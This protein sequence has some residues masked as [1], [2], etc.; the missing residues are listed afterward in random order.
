MKKKTPESIIQQIPWMP[1]AP[2]SS[3]GL[4]DNAWLTGA[5]GTAGMS[6][7]SL[8]ARYDD[9]SGMVR[10]VYITTFQKK[11]ITDRSRQ[12]SF[13]NE[14]NSACNKLMQDY[15]IGTGFEYKV[16]PTKDGVNQKLIEQVQELVDLYCEHNEM[17]K[18]EN[19][20]VWRLLVEGE[21]IVRNFAGR[22]GLLT[23]RVVEPE[24][25][26]P[27]A[28]SNNPDSSYGIEC[29]H[30]DIH[31]PVGYWIVEK[32]YEGLIPVL[33]PA[34]EINFIKMNTPSNSKRGLPMSFQVDSNFRNCESVLQSM[35][36]LANA[37][38]KVA[39]VRKIAEAP[40][41]A[42]A[43]LVA[44]TTD[45]VLNDPITNQ[46]LNIERL[47]YG[48]V[49]TSSENITYEFPNINLG[50]TDMIE[51][52]QQNLRAICSHYGLSE[53]QISSNPN[54]SNYASSV[55]AESPS[56][57]SFLRWQKVIGEFIAG[58]RTKPQQSMI[59]KQISYAVKRG[60]LPENSLTD[61]KVS[62][63]GPSVVTRD[64]QA[65]ANANK[66]YAD[67]GVKSNQDIAAEIGMSYDEQKNHMKNDDSLVKI[68]Q[69]VTSLKEAGIPLEAAKL[70]FKK[71]HENIDD[72]IIN[73]M[74]LS[75]E[76]EIVPENSVKNEKP[77]QAKQPIPRPPQP[78]R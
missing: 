61:I 27:P 51:T 39:M 25:L 13:F 55:V 16:V 42:M 38:S 43:S 57:K 52:L 62:Y 56:C 35:I 77:E 18:F 21:C 60:L 30:D 36:S 23:T 34:D 40:P 67:M 53:I 14:Y 3:D 8:A 70:L 29:V 37:R 10:P 71:Y 15:I 41:D 66:I 22:D 63:K 58:R 17:S 75:K 7:Y 28:D 5:W 31:R 20:L 54:N 76:P 68:L 33:V 11:Q 6:P 50:S 59:W 2:W 74:F 47:A 73:S 4:Y 69:T 26:L 12:L 1:Y 9:G 72:A 65:E 45:V 19:E 49:L 78:K 64:L 46:N 24:L 44:K 48:S 32:P